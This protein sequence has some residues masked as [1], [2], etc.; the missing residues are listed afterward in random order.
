MRLS[1][2]GES[3]MNQVSRP[4]ALVGSNEPSWRDH[5]WFSVQDT[6]DQDHV[7]TPAGQVPQPAGDRQVEGNWVGHTHVIGLISACAVRI[8]RART[9]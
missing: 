3:L 4:H 7:L 2:S 9:Q 1:A 8:L 6:A 5:Y